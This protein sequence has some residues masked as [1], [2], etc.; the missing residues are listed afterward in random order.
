MHVNA[1]TCLI[2]CNEIQISKN[3]ISTS[4]ISLTV[5]ILLLSYKNYETYILSRAKTQLCLNIAIH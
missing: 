5:V 2:V 3:Y 4:I 1:L